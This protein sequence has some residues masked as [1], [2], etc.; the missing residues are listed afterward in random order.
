MVL[1]RH[2]DGGPNMGL[3]MEP[4]P[5]AT[6]LLRGGLLAACCLLL[7]LSGH[8]VGGGGAPSAAPVLLG[9]A[10]VAAGCVAWAGR[11]RSVRQLLT[12]AAAAQG[13]FHLTLSLAPAHPMPG[14]PL[15]PDLRMLAGHAAATVVMVAV[16]AYGERVLDAL[17]RT[18]ARALLVV[19]RD[20]E[21]YRPV[22]VPATGP[23]DT[24]ATGVLVAAGCPRRGPPART[25]AA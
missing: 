25:A 9:G 11:P 15:I 3:A 7:G 20:P 1:G 18:A 17:A 8:L 24:T 14:H 2:Y 12:A 6:R 4:G 19:P 16:L 23:D 10:L 13:A 5:D 21:G 22:R